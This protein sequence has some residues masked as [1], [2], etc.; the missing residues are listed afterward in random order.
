MEKVPQGPTAN[1]SCIVELAMRKR[2]EGGGSE[3][4]THGTV[5]KLGMYGRP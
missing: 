3:V 1:M 5:N 2:Q 4:V